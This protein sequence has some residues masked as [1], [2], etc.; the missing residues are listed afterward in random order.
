M[1]LNSASFHPRP[2]AALPVVRSDG[3]AI[4]PYRILGRESNRD[5]PLSAE[6]TE[7]VFR[8]LPRAREGPERPPVGFVIEHLATP[9]DYLVIC[10]WENKN[11]LAT[12][13]LTR[14][15][16]ADWGEPPGNESFCVWDFDIMWFERNAFIR[17]MLSF[18]PADVQAYI[19][20]RFEKASV[21]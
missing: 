9:L 15:E 6:S 1:T 11:E 21:G 2:V 13:I 7:A 20:A 12:R 17:T 19:A 14:S 18:A 4:K 16:G 8:T 10:W 3:W 5:E